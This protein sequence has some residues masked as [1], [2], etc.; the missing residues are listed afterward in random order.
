MNMDDYL[1]EKFPWL[2]NLE[3][4]A[5]QIVTVL[6][7]KEKHYAGSWQQRGGPG[8][9]MMLARKWDRIENAAKKE[10]YDIFKVIKHNEAETVDDIDDL[11]GY[12]MLVRAK[13]MNET[14]QM[15]LN[16][17]QK[18]VDNPTLTGMSS[19]YGFDE[20]DDALPAPSIKHKPL[21]G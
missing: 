7:D 9:F 15:E 17:A 3:P 2:K 21:K 8:A 18:I 5:K 14:K 1:E 4:L 16:K 11:I 20:Q 19:P 10:N 6:H 12:L 13:M